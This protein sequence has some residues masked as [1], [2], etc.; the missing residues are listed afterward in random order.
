MLSYERSCTPRHPVLW[1]CVSRLPSLMGL[2]YQVFGSTT[3]ATAMKRHR[4][5]TS[6]LP[7]RKRKVACDRVSLADL[8]IIPRRLIASD[9]HTQCVSDVRL[10]TCI[11][12][13]TRALQQ[14]L[15]IEQSVSQGNLNRQSLGHVPE[16]VKDEVQK[17]EVSTVRDYRVCQPAS[18]V[19]LTRPVP[20]EPPSGCP[21]SEKG[22]LSVYNGGRSVYVG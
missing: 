20:A 22:L 3:P 19:L 4:P 17:T 8:E 9:S 12:S 5:V 15:P 21:G 14:A 11:V 18:N 7:C 2:N 1:F 6:C 13:M 16:L 10:D